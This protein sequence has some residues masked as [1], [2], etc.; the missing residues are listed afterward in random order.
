MSTIPM[1]DDTRNDSQPPL[2]VCPVCTDTLPIDGRGIYCTPKCR[3]RAYRLR[4]R[5]MNR[6]TLT[7]LAARLRREQ[8]L[9]AHTV[10]ECPSCQERFLGERRCGDC[11][12]WCSKVGLGGQCAGCDDI[13]TVSDLIGFDLN[14]REVP[15]SDPV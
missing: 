13:L 1:R 14:S 15:L 6:P 4:H 12:L 8:Q 10:Y 2:G 9:S 7:D 5:Q 11:N 3:Q